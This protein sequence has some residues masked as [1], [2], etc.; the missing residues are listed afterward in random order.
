MH[1]LAI[2]QTR[3]KAPKNQ[4]NKFGGYS[5]RS[6]EDILE[7]Y[8]PLETE[9]GCHL[10]LKD[11]IV[12]IGERYY[13]KAEAYLFDEDKLIGTSTGY[14]QEG[15][16]RGMSPGQQTGSASSYARKYCLAGLFLCDDT[17]DPDFYPPPGKM[18]KAETKENTSNEQKQKELEERI[19]LL[20]KNNLL[21][22]RKFQ[23]ELKD[24]MIAAINDPKFN[25]I[26][27]Q[28]T[29]L[30]K[31]KEKLAQALSETPPPAPNSEPTFTVPF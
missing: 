19:D 17:K 10:I 22:A 1:K 12:H 25:S 7:A 5:Y 15:E 8:K 9:L 31:M 14:A 24:K 21:H 4:F 13:V 30:K 6:L 27:G 23:G 28:E 2:I 11:E 3:L 16:Q 20:K 18:Q 26:N 29:I